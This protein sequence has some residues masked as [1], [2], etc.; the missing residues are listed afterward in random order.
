MHSVLL[1]FRHAQFF[2]DNLPNTDLFLIQLICN[3]SNS[4]QKSPPPT[5]LACLMLTS[6]LLVEDLLLLELS[7]TYLQHSL[8]LLCHSKTHG[9]H[10]VLSSYT[11]WSISSASDWVFLDQTKNFCF[12]CSSVFIA[13]QPKK[14]RCRQKHVKKD[15]GSR[16]LRFWSNTPKI[17]C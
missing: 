6:V 7:F 4:Q 14:E 13:E 16:K 3:H 1:F 10:M 8:N 9:C 12:I 2:G 5:C 17:D 15:N 11:H